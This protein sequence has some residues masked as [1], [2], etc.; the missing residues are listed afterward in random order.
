MFPPVFCPELNSKAL[1]VLGLRK[2]IEIIKSV[3]EAAYMCCIADIF[4]DYTGHASNLTNH[5]V[6]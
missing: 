1:A 2:I 3:V 6:P 5:S 4:C